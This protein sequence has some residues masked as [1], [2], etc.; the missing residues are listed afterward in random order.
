MNDNFDVRAVLVATDQEIDDELLAALG[1]GERAEFNALPLLGKR[2]SEWLAGRIAAKRAVQ[3]RTGLPFERI[4]IATVPGSAPRA[5]IDGVDCELL[6][7]ITHSNGL[8]AAIVSEDPIGID[9]ERI[10]PREPSFETL[11]FADEERRAFEGLRGPARDVAVTRAWCEKEALSKWLGEGLKIAFFDLVA[12][13]HLDPGAIKSGSFT[14]AN[15]E[16]FAW[17]VVEGERP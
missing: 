11:V 2:R 9:L 16:S 8:A 3:Q 5:L 14:V 4:S 12:T 1:A 15:G 17:A 7:S 13:R 10:E 6:L